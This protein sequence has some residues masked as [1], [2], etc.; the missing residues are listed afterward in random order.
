M[1]RQITIGSLFDGIG[2]F[3]YAA[4]F[5]GIKAVWA[6][7]ILPCAISVTR[8]H[9]PDM[10][11]VGDITK[12]SGALLPPVDII[13]FGS[14][15]QDL[16]VAKGHRDGLSGERSGLFTEAIR[17]IKEMRESTH[18][19]YPRFA[20]WENVPGAFHSRHGSDFKTVLEAFTDCEI[21]MPPSGR[22]ASAGMV[23]GR[24]VD[25]AWCVYNAAEFG[26][27]QRRKR[28]FLVADFGGTGAGKI[29]FIPKGLPRHFAAGGKERE[30]VAAPSAGSSDLSNAKGIN[31]NIAGTL[32]AHYNKGAGMRGGTEREIV[33]AFI[34]KASAKAQSVGYSEK[35]SPTLETSMPPV[36]MRIR[37]GCEGGGK[38][39]L[40]QIDKSGTLAT[41]NDQYLFAPADNQSQI[42][43]L[44]DQGGASMSVEKGGHAPTLRH[45]TH[46]NLP[47]ICVASTQA[48]ASVNDNLC[49]TITAAAGMSGNNKPYV[50]HPEK[51]GTLCASGAGLNRPGGQGS[52]TE[53][54]VAYC[55][56]GN[57]IGRKDENGPEG[58]GV[59]EE[60]SYTLNTTDKHGVAYVMTT[61]SFPQVCKEQSPTLSARDYKDASIVAHTFGSNSYSGW[62]EGAT[63]TLKASGGCYG[64]G[65]EN[66]AVIPPPPYIVRRLT[67]TE[68]E[69]L[70]GFPDGWT[71]YEDSGKEISDSKRY[72]M[73]GNSV[74][75]PCVAHV[76]RG[77]AEEIRQGDTA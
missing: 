29:L 62:D 3:P 75:I 21:S 73:L 28:I 24:S 33:A 35:V 34:G 52:E 19:Q 60:I 47:V 22:W 17:I 54:C 38:G 18:G 16:S 31:G 59:N 51:S 39:A 13:T 26:L 76:M 68:C 48:D 23:R 53:L 56:Q 63:A 25:L 6:S 5:Y 8:R 45:S 42:E 20:V 1:N 65:S 32:D 36:T 10:L 41:G 14:P 72:Q 58:N 37:A 2:G 27:A 77:I 70:Q 43:I 30:S 12:L 66:L 44:N 67:P 69:R 64:G 7:E 50:V 15:C 74:A 46:G 55:L 11:H 61:G 71:A 49:P 57:M 9:F 4:S 40:L